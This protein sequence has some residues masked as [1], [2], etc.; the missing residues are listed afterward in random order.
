[1]AR[2]K[3]P[4]IVWVEDGLI[5]VL[6][7]NS[8][9]VYFTDF[10]ECL[11]NLV[12]GVRWHVVNNGYLRGYINKE[13]IYLHHLILP[14]KDGF[15]IDHINR[16]KADNRWCNLRYVTPTENLINRGLT[17]ANT[18]GYLGVY[19]DNEREKWSACIKLNKKTKRLGRFLTKEEAARAYLEA[20]EKYYP[21]ILYCA[22]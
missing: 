9:G 11:Y 18:S 20:V 16:N 21:G 5:K 15:W 22:I 17:R 7:V 3:E 12:S 6:P 8:K 2:R 14:P 4:A 10:T 1:M 19:W 13:L